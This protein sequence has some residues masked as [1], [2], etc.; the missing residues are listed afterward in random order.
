[1]EYCIDDKKRSSPILRNNNKVQTFQRLIQQDYEKRGDE[2]KY[3]NS[4]PSQYSFVKR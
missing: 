4:I 2:D 3:Q 1:M